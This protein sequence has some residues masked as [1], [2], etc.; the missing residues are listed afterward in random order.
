[1]SGR[2][3]FDDVGKPQQRAP[4]SF[5]KASNEVKSRAT[6]VRQMVRESP[7]QVPPDLITGEEY[8][9]LEPRS[10]ELIQ[11]DMLDDQ[12]F[13]H[14]ET[15]RLE[16]LPTHQERM[17]AAKAICRRDILLDDL[18]A[19]IRVHD[20][21]SRLRKESIKRLV[22]S[23]VWALTGIFFLWSCVISKDPLVAAGVAIV[24]HFG[25]ILLIWVASFFVGLNK[26][27]GRAV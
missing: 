25:M 7:A 15:H 19:E 6:E 24:C 10:L 20:V 11:Q 4:A 8:D 27:A 21:E 17:R 18:N 2:N 26:V 3:P 12:R 9:R 14:T 13:R 5:E 22:L 23:T 16:Y 1:M